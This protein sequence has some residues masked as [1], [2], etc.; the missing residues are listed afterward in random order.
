MKHL[1]GMLFLLVA[2]TATS[3]EVVSTE[4]IQT[5]SVE[6]IQDVVDNLGIPGG[7]IPVLYPVDFYRV[8]YMTEHPNGNDVEVSGALCVPQAG[9]CPLPVSSYQHGT[10]SMKTDAPSFQS[11]EGMLALLYASS[12]YLSVAADYI[13]LGTGEGLHLYVHAESEAEACLDLIR[14]AEELQEELNYNISDQLFIWGYSQGGHATAALQRKIET[15]A[16]EEYTITASAP[17]SGPYDISGVQ[18]DVITSDNI[19]PTPGY[20]PYVVMSYQEAYG[21]LYEDLEEVFLPQYAEQFPDL[22]DGTHGM[23]EINAVCP[24]VPNQ[25]LQP[26]FFTAFQ[27]DPDHPVRAALADNDLLDWAPQVPTTL[28]YC[29]QDDQVNYQNSLIALDAYEALGSTSVTA[30]DMGP[31]NHSFCAPFAMFQGF[32]FFESYRED[33]FNPA[34]SASINGNSG[35][36]GEPNGSIEVV[37][38]A[39]GDWSFAWS[40]GE[41]ELSIFG[42]EEGVYTLDVYSEEGCLQSYDFEIDTATGLVELESSPISLY[43]VPVTNVLHFR[44][45]QAVRGGIFDLQGKLIVELNMNGSGSIDLSD[46]P[47]GVYVFKSLDGHRSKIIKR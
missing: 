20:L 28:Y 39:P 18:A 3:Q 13:G 43:P 1:I 6:E 21:N 36:P 44:S 37:I 10:I 9:L 14:A 23:G 47:G 38:D 24:N 31:Y 42:L 5:Y 11:T 46:I 12:G 15:E 34:M 22:F 45:E 27:T 16:F 26:D 17:M 40:N 2:F 25:M 29:N 19:Y 4:L 41:E 8:T 7:F 35:A 33:P 30:D 32:N